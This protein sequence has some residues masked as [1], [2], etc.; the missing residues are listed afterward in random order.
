MQIGPLQIVAIGFKDD[1]NLRGK[2]KEELAAVRGRGVIK[3]I[4]ALF[5]RRDDQG[6]LSVIQ[7]SDFTQAEFVEYGCAIKRLLG[8]D[9]GAGTNGGKARTGSRVVGIK[10]S[11]VKAVADKV[12][13]GTAVALVLFEHAW[14]AELSAAISEAGGKTLAQGFL[15]R[16]LVSAI[17]AELLAI[18][19][20]EKIIEASRAVQAAT[21]VNTLAFPSDGDD[22]AVQPAPT[23]DEATTRIA[24]RALRALAVAGVVD[25]SEMEVAVTALLESGLVSLPAVERGVAA[26]LA[27][28]ARGAALTAAQSANA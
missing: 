11:D 4:D 17:R 24:A 26:A 7:D 20:A 6:V 19:K 2:I 3:L 22:E 14:A 10:P 9:E 18:A 23:A 27:Q 16:D 21:V 15:T 13:P 1:D 12:K 8:I 5:V 28:E 25:A